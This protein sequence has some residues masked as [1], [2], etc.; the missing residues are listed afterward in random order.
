MS[1]LLIVILSI[2][3]CQAQALPKDSL[4]VSYYIENDSINITF[5]NL[6][7]K[8]LFLLKTYFK[9]RYLDS[10]YLFRYDDEN[11]VFKY[12]FLPL[13][14]YLNTDKSDKLIITDE[15]VLLNFQSVY[16]FLTIPAQHKIMISFSHV[17]ICGRLE[18]TTDFKVIKD[19]N[20]QEIDREDIKEI[21]RSEINTSNILFE[22]AIYESVNLLTIRGEELRNSRRFRQQSKAF[23]VLTLNFECS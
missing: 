19:F 23:K 20:P 14:R 18:K 16:E 12:S 4:Q 1:R 5:E 17:D 3:L 2:Q 15:A 7:S 6:S 10:K 22:F 13:I 11:N 21:K 9:N 8:P